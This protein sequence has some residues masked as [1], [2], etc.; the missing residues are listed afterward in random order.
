[1]AV[2][3]PSSKYPIVIPR[4]IREQLG[5]EPGKPLYINMVT[6]GKEAR[7]STVSVIDRYAGTLK[8]AWGDEDPAVWLR[9]ERDAWDR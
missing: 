7:I 5:I 3:K 6:G 8:G 9:R 1:M 4:K 2:V